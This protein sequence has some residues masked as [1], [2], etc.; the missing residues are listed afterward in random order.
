MKRKKYLAAL[1]AAALMLAGGAVGVSAED[2]AL[3]LRYLLEDTLSEEQQVNVFVSVEETPEEIRE[4]VLEYEENGETLSCSASEIVENSMVFEL[5]GTADREYRRVRLAVGESEYTADVSAGEELPVEAET[6]AQAD[7]GL[8]GEDVDGFVVSGNT[9]EE[10]ETSVGAA[11]CLADP[12][13]MPNALSIDL[14][15]QTPWIVLDPG[16]GGHDPGTTK[17]WD[18]TLYQEKDM[19]LKISWATRRALNEKYP[20]VRVTM[21]RTDDT[22]ISLSYRTDYAASVGA[23]VLVSQHINSAGGSTTTANGVEALVARVGT[24]NTEVAQT[25]Q[26]LA[27]AIL[28][29]LVA[30]GY[31]DR[32]FVIKS[33]TNGS[34]YADGSPADYYSIVA[35][36]MSN[37]IPG[38]IIEHGFINNEH[39]FRTYLQSD[40]SL[41]R[42]GQADARGIAKFLNLDS[43]PAPEPTPEPT[44][45]PAPEPTPTPELAPG[46]QMIGGIYYYINPDGTIH[47]GWL[48]E[49]GRRYYLD[50]ANGQMQAGWKEIDGAWYY[51]NASGVM[52]TGWQVVG[53]RYEYYYLGDDGKRRTGWQEIDGEW[54]YLNPS[55]AMQF[56]WLSLDGSRYWLGTSGNMQVGWQKIDGIYY[57]FNAS[58]IMQTGWLHLGQF[59]YYLEPNGH[60]HAG[61]HVENGKRYFFNASG[62]LVR[63]ENL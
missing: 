15:R 40:A 63:E 59:T 24:F 23:T 35:N 32:G 29:E 5:P 39:D 16:H 38:I 42:L 36:S 43:Q 51:L 60:M 37:G 62:L 44:P 22:Y 50:P 7:T 26:G 34:T 61:W 41:E 6:I 27:R 55:G 20:N 47:R 25:G 17:V 30:L 11:V 9:E 53:G 54:Y 58:G 19:T 4:A 46:W 56:G 18:G 3:E 21:T 48:E 28:D 8:T 31:K 49:D 52:Q 13:L 14:A 10:I 33:S 57:F 1:A 45:E 2:G 12:Y